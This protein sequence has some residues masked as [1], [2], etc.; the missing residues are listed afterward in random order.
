MKILISFIAPSGYGKST[1][2]K[3]LQEKYAIENIKIAEPLY[4]LQTLF[5]KKIN[6]DIGDN[7][8]G[9]LLQFFGNK[10]RKENPPYLLETFNQKISQSEKQ[11]I[12]NDDCRPYDYNFLKEQGF[13][14]IK[15]KGFPHQRNDH[16]IANP[17][18]NLEWQTEIPCDYEIENYSDLKTY[19]EN[20]FK[21]VEEILNKEKCI[22]RKKVKK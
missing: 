21:V 18:S 3:I 10:V 6:K 17:K 12:T 1:A 7:Q 4:E 11:I 15:I 16:T 20:I 19:K 5:Y 2:I 14:F 22:V 13:I 8:D 9:E